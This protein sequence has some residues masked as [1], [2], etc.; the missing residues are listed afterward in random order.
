VKLRTLKVL[1]AEYVG[2]GRRQ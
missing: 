2:V 1:H